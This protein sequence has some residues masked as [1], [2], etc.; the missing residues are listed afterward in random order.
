MI[1]LQQKKK[2]EDNTPQSAMMQSIIAKLTSTDESLTITN[3]TVLQITYAKW[4]R[5]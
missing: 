2:L 1:F 4:I 3:R 5:E